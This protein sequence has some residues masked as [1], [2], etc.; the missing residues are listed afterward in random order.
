MEFK[1]IKNNIPEEIKEKG[2][3]C[4]YAAIQNDELFVD[5]L[6][7]ALIEEVNNF[8]TTGS[9]DKLVELQVLIDSF[10]SFYTEAFEK[11]Y[12][13]KIAN[14]EIYSNKYI[15]FFY[16]DQQEPQNST[17]IESITASN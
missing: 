17:V 2:G 14:N 16:D 12:S 8:L 11:A 7:L 4:N 15:G 3:L 13:T 9:L 5:F 10:K 6:K 1:L